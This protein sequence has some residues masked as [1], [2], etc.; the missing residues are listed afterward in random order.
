[1]HTRLVIFEAFKLMEIYI[2]RRFYFCSAQTCMTLYPDCSQ[3]K[4]C[5]MKIKRH[6]ISALENEIST[7]LPAK[8]DSDVLFFYN[9]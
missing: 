7:V 9:Y 2:F 8:S 6:F 1:M 5:R 3:Q 4:K